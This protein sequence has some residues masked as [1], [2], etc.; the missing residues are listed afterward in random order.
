MTYLIP[1]PVYNVLKWG[2]LIVLPALATLVGTVG[3][4]WGMDAGLSSS[5]TTT[6]TAV[7]AFGG[8]VLGVSAAT[9]RPTASHM[10]GE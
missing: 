3:Q 9:A 2:C 1:D 5:I 7:G 8:V 4:A 10:G 6:I